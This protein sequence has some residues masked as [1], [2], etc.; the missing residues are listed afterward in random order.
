M[1]HIYKL[2]IILLSVF[3]FIGCNVDDDDP[4]TVRADKAL[5]AS[6]ANQGAIVAIADDATTYD[7]VVNFSE[8]LPSY[9]TVAYSIDGNSTSISR[10]TGES[11]LTISIPFATDEN[12]HIVVL[13][14]FI[15]VNSSARGF[16]TSIDGTT[17]VRI[18][19]Q[20]YFTATMNWPSA[21]NDLDLGLQPMTDAWADTF[22]WIDTSLGTTN[23]EFVEAE[24][25][26]NGNYALFIQH[27]TAAAEV[28]VVFTIENAA[29]SSIINVTTTGD[30]NVIWFTKSG[31][32]YTFF[33][34]DPA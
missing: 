12:F 31:T 18:A 6:L 7:L 20:G 27:F 14:E 26:P 13:S 32:N 5:T 28:D 15:V 29:G 9:A 1:K 22:A 19:R 21:A 10:N 16:V 23:Q 24:G 2:S 17:T 8:A 25:L 3:T 34:E 30:G 33:T 11:S 4:I